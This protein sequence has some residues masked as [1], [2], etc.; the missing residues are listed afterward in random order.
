LISNI[1]QESVKIDD[2]KTTSELMGAEGR[3]RQ[4]YYQGFNDIL[5]TDVT[6]EKRVRQP[7]DNPINALISFGNSLMYSAALSE[8]YRTQLNP[9]ISFL[10]EP[11]ATRLPK[12]RRLRKSSLFF[13]R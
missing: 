1:Q 10:H 6:F 2:V 5:N 12:S 3:I 11:N 4:Q 9:T 7:P 8:I 13:I